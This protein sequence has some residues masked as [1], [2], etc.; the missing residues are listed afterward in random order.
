MTLPAFATTAQ[1]ASSLGVAVPTDSLIL[2]RWQDA[3]DD[4]SGYLRTLIG[5][6]ITAGTAHLNLT[7]DERGE[8]DIWLVPVTAVTSITDPEGNVLTTDD[9]ELVDQRLNL[10]RAHTQYAVVL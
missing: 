2:S 8:A 5:Q 6:P 10:R 3:L 9:W 4:A 1:L 7:T